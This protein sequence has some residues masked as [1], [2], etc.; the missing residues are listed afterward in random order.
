MRAIL[1]IS[2]NFLAVL[3][4]GLADKS[5]TEQVVVYV[6]FTHP[7]AHFPVLKFFHTIAHSVSQDAPGLK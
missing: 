4:D 1:Y 2:L 3:C 5:I 6:I 7:E